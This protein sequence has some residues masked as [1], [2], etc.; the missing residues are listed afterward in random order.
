MTLRYRLLA[1][2]ASGVVGLIV[3]LGVLYALAPV[4]GWY[5]G[6]VASFMAAVSVTWKLNRSFAF[7]DAQRALD[8]SVWRQYGRYV[9]SMLVGAGVN[10]MTYAVTLHF[11]N[12]PA[13]PALGVALGSLVGL[14]VNFLSAQLLVFH[15]HSPPI[16]KPARKSKPQR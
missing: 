14:S 11:V 7:K 2:C 16:R 15:T 5:A 9:A 6:R 12:L 3:D 10:Y 8:E 4:L 13:A 1:F